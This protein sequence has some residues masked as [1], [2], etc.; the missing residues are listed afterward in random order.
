MP[1]TPA[2]LSHGLGSF[3]CNFFRSMFIASHNFLTPEVRSARRSEWSWTSSVIF[4]LC[5][6][7]LIIHYESN[8][9]SYMS[10]TAHRKTVPHDDFFFLLVRTRASSVP[11]VGLVHFLRWGTGC[12]NCCILWE[13][14][15]ITPILQLELQILVDPSTEDEVLCLVLFHWEQYF[16]IFCR[17]FATE[18]RLL[19]QKSLHFLGP[20]CNFATES[21]KSCKSTQQGWSSTSDESSPSMAYSIRVNDPTQKGKYQDCLRQLMFHYHNRMHQ[22]FV[23]GSLASTYWKKGA[24]CPTTIL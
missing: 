12:T 6:F 18:N 1:G 15:H 2:Y 16:T 19:L 5:V 24:V 14:F 17:T 11:Y 7:S 23:L 20:N 8:L 3:H 9:S 4:K 21:S 13:Y 22:S 10:T